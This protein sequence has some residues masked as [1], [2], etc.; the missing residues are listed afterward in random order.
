[1]KRKKPRTQDDASLA[2]MPEDH[3]PVLNEL[4]HPLFENQSA[5]HTFLR[6]RL[7][8][9]AIAE[10]LF[11]QS[12]IRAVERHPSLKNTESVVTW[13]YQI[14][15]HA[16]IDYYRSQGAEARRNESFLQE[17]TVTGNDKEPSIDDVQETVCMC[18]HRLLPSLRSNYAELIRRIDLE[19]ESP[20][21]VGEELKISPNN[22][23]VR[24]HRA[25]QALRASLEQA[26]GI[27]SQHG[28]LNCTC[29]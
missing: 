16:L 8:D 4:L 9:D 14:L 29:G 22:L 10:D 23:T 27:C 28:C 13:F 15:R 19:G 17:L 1:M 3:G 5:F 11:Q 7:R 26:C 6:G 21:H 2:N 18:L 12:M 24:L 25:R 20:K